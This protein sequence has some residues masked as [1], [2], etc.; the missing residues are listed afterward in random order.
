LRFNVDYS[1]NTNS[2]LYLTGEYRRGDAV[3]SGLP[4]LQSLDIAKVFARDDAFNDQLF[5]YRFNAVTWLATMGYN[6]PFGSRDSLDFSFR[7]VYSVSTDAS[8]VYGKS[9]YYTDQVSLTYLM[10]F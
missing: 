7:H 3:S 4:S 2:T 1:V 5:A 6:L 8:I 9:R 10:R